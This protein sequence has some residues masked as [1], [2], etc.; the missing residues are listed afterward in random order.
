MNFNH[1]KR[2]KLVNP[3]A[4]S[5]SIGTQNEPVMIKLVMTYLFKSPWQ[6][7]DFKICFH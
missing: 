6:I 5:K 7:F 2:K 4:V 1:I 3:N